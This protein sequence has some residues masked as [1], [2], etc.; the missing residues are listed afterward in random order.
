MKCSGFKKVDIEYDTYRKLIERPKKKIVV[1]NSSQIIVRDGS[2]VAS[3]LSQI[4]VRDRST[5]SPSML[6]IGSG[7]T[8]IVGSPPSQV[9]NLVT[10]STAMTKSSYVYINPMS[11]EVFEFLSKQLFV[12]KS[13]ESIFAHLFFVLDW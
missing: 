10:P 6:T 2:I 12:S 4:V 13:K 11:L 7:D 9:V 5:S 3:H 1:L 8:A